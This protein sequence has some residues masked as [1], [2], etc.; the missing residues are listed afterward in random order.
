MP[1]YYGYNWWI[2]QT[3]SDYFGILGGTASSGNDTFQLGGYLGE[4][5][6]NNDWDY[7]DGG[8]GT[9]RIYVGSISGYAWTAIMVA[10]GGFNS[11]ETIDG[12]STYQPIYA[13][14]DA[15]FSSITTMSSGVKFFGRGNDNTITT[16][17]LDDYI[18]GDGGDDI[19]YA[20]TGDDEIW[21]DNN[22]IQTTNL[23]IDDVNAAGDDILFGQAGNDTIYGGDGNDQL[24]GG[25]DVDELFGGDGDDVL[26]AGAGWDDE[27][28]GGAGTD[29]FLI[30]EGEGL[31]TVKDFDN[32][33]DYIVAGS[34][35]DAITIYSYIGGDALLLMDDTYVHLEGVAAGLIDGADFLYA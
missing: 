12:S 7:F 31:N 2:G 28:T 11:V 24:Y 5:G 23:W 8:S 26:S 29:Y 6:I 1:Y 9:D 21:G 35:I 10:D 22:S 33:T 13:Q 30:E 27:L 19:I 3:G 4:G 17:G 18:E 25:A 14:G 15:D 32:G 16:T 20:G 34:S